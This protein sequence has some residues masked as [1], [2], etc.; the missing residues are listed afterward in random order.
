MRGGSLDAVVVFGTVY[1]RVMARTTE[2]DGPIG[3]LGVEQFFPLLF[4]HK[5]LL[6]G[7]RKGA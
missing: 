2:Y 4:L 5:T 7:G 6:A 3:R 1:S